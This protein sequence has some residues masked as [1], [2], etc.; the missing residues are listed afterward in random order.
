[1]VT[2]NGDW[3]WDFLR[4]MVVKDVPIIWKAPSIGWYKINV[5]GA[6]ITTIGVASA[7]GL[8]RDSNGNWICGF[9][10]LIGICSPLQAELWGVLDVLRVAWQKGCV[11]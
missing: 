2:D 9:N 5:D 10:R 11:E 1:M 3:Y 8:V 6:V 7:G 4:Q